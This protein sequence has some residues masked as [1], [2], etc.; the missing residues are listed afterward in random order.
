MKVISMIFLSLFLVKGC[1]KTNSQELA[2]TQ[3]QYIANSRGMY[4][5]ITIQNQEV[6]ISKDRNQESN[7]VT[8]KISDADW[9]ELVSLFSKVDLEQLST[10]EGPTQKRFHDGAPM[11]NMIV[12]YKEKEYLSTTFDHGTPPVAIADLVN[13][14]VSLAK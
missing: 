3:I 2:D 11:A 9:K 8:T 5:K 14:V 10:Y 4:Q 13:K 6:S 7:G 1:S 12:K